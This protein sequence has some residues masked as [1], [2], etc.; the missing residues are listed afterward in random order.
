[1]LTPQDIRQIEEHG[2]S[3]EQIER[4][5]E[6]FRTGFPYLNLA[7]AAVAGDGICLLYTSDAADE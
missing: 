1:M 6:R 4:Q 7:R 2:L 3:P 5:M